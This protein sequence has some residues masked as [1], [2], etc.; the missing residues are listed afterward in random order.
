MAAHRKSASFG[1]AIKSKNGGPR[2]SKNHPYMFHHFADSINVS[3]NTGLQGEL[4]LTRELFAVKI[5]EYPSTA[6]TMD[7]AGGPASSN[8]WQKQFIRGFDEGNLQ[9]GQTRCGRR[10]R[11]AGQHV[12]DGAFRMGARRYVLRPSWSHSL[13]EGDGQKRWDLGMEG[14]FRVDQRNQK[15]NVGRSG[16][17]DSSLAGENFLRDYTQNLSDDEFSLQHWMS[18]KC[19]RNDASVSEH[20]VHKYPTDARR[21]VRGDKV[22][23]PRIIPSHSRDVIE[24]TNEGCRKSMTKYINKVKMSEPHKKQSLF[25]GGSQVQSSFSVHP[26]QR[27]GIAEAVKETWRTPTRLSSTSQRI[28]R[29]VPQGVE[30]SFDGELAVLKLPGNGC[31][32]PCLRAYRKNQRKT[33]PDSLRNSSTRGLSDSSRRKCGPSTKQC[34]PETSRMKNAEAVLLP[35]EQLASSKENGTCCVDTSEKGASGKLA[36]DRQTAGRELRNMNCKVQEE[37]GITTSSPSEGE[38]AASIERSR[39]LSEKYRP[40]M[41]KDLLGQNLVVNAL[42]NAISRDKV[43]PVYL[44]QGS[45]GTGKT[46]AARIFAAALNCVTSGD[47]KPCGCCSECTALVSG[48]TSGIWELDAASHNGIGHLKELIQGTVSASSGSRYK[49]V[50]ID[51]CHIFSHET[52]NALMRLFEEPPGNTI[53]ILITTDPDKLPLTVV[54]RCQKFHF[55]QIKHLDIVNRL[56][57]VTKLENLDAEPGALNLIASKSEGSLRDAEIVLEQASLLGQRITLATIHQLLFVQIQSTLYG[58]QETS[59]IQG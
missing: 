44:F 13:E 9:T 57:T 11:K 2:N 21:L 46:S 18:F 39:S 54:S 55:L 47:K 51:E 33:L 50:I 36:S 40:K 43:A 3:L 56:D 35:T 26:T 58:G 49:I 1:G 24:L 6:K 19:I 48:K 32:K 29:G 52:W 23:R 10:L 22:T 30:Q 16:F 17:K 59:L 37:D 41:L 31:R 15:G 7:P 4:P 28:L 8:S 25:Q 14:T 34:I 27:S 45:H 42:S 20:C 38:M 12:G 5:L 53:I